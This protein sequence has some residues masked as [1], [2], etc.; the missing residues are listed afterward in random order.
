M[1]TCTYINTFTGTNVQIFVKAFTFFL[2]WLSKCC[3]FIMPKLSSSGM[4]ISPSS[5]EADQ[6]ATSDMEVPG[7]NT[8]M[9]L[10]NPDSG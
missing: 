3:I 10:L 8:Q 6:D 9:P 4:A 7:F 5:Q 2:L 1:Y